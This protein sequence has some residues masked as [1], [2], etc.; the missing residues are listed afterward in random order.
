[1]NVVRELGFASQD[2]LSGFQAFAVGAHA[3]L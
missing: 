2:A 1:M 3:E